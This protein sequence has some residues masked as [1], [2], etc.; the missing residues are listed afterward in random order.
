MTFIQRLS[1]LTQSFFSLPRWVIVWVLLVLIPVNTASFALFGAPSGQWAA[2]AWIFVMVVNTGT[3]FYYGGV[4]KSMSIPHLVAWVP[5]EIFLLMRL[6]GGEMEPAGAEFGYAV[7]LAVINGIS[8]VFDGY[9]SYRWLRGEREVVA[10][11]SGN[12]Q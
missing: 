1:A 7:L 10:R 11:G 12:D 2:I 9:D 6:A 8:L 4:T 3:L 5:L